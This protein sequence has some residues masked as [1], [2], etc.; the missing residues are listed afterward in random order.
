MTDPGKAVPASDG[1]L[2]SLL[3][4]GLHELGLD[5]EER[6]V[7]SLLTFADLLLHW[8]RTY[9]LTAIRTPRD[10]VTHHLLDCLAIVPALERQLS[11][12][13]GR[14]I[15]D[16]GSGAGLPGL[17]IAI[18]DPASQVVCVDSVGK[19]AAFITQAIACL[20]LEN[21]EAVHGRVEML[22]RPGFD[23]I[24]SRAFSSLADF[25]RAT[26]RLL[27]PGGVWMAMKG[28]LPAAE[29]QELGP[30]FMAHVEPV[31]VPEVDAERCLVR[32]A[33]SS[34]SRR[35]RPLSGISRARVEKLPSS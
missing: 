32:I 16:V 27:S 18:V 19:K 33:R 25:V 22:E 9:N 30:S 11:R 35:E 7:A 31:R 26:E 8:N 3:E 28:R 21:A 4:A 1:E 23:V 29:L 17:V 12:T 2:R 10:V 6:R 13:S 20:G 34:E 15:L 5:V 14:R 24:V